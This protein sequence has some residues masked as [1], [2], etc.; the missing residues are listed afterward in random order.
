MR[1]VT[2][3]LVSLLMCQAQLLQWLP[4]RLS[5]EKVSISLVESEVERVLL[6]AI[7]HSEVRFVHSRDS[8]QRQTI[9]E[10]KVDFRRGKANRN[11]TRPP[12]LQLQA[13]SQPNLAL[14]PACGDHQPCG[15]IEPPN[16]LL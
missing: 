16:L 5:R 8:L 13:V 11:P 7:S 12:T 6:F 3:E 15:E 14:Y 1:R 10:R 4:Q 9:W 2:Q